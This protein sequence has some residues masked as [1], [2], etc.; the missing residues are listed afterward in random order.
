MSARSKQAGGR[1]GSSRKKQQ[2]C[3]RAVAWKRSRIRCIYSI[4]PAAT[5][6]AAWHPSRTITAT[7]TIALATAAIAR[8]FMI[9]VLLGCSARPRSNSPRA[10]S[11]SP[12]S[13]SSCGQLL[14]SCLLRLSSSYARSN[15]SRA[16][17]KLRALYS[18]RPARI[19][20]AASPPHLRRPSSMTTRALRMLSDVYSASAQACSTTL[21]PPW[22][23]P[24]RGN[25][26]GENASVKECGQT[27][28]YS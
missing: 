15:S 28:S 3:W 10:R 19:R 4:A 17:S 27:L 2:P 23:R 25:G 5:M 1:Q 18:M 24:C 20:M 9:L 7:T 13:A 22:C 6:P 12:A 21:P 11:T 8:T 14:N 26:G 16:A